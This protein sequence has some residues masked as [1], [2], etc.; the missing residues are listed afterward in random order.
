MSIVNKTRGK[1][2]AG[3]YEQASSEGA[4]AGTN[5]TAIESGAGALHKTV[6]NLAA[7]P[8]TMTDEP[9]VILH[10]GVK[11]YD[12]AAGCIL[13]LGATS[14]IVA[15]GGGNVDAAAAGDFSAGSVIASN[16]NTL[17]S[18]EATVIPSTAYTLSSSTGD[19]NGQSTG[20]TYIDGTGTDVDLYFNVLVDDS[21]HTGGTITL[22]GTITLIWLNLGTY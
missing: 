4:V 21:D 15:T 8:V 16:N 19:L 7:T 20:V 2:V 5:V 9:G 10:G 17:T 13:I 6:F 11:I 18:T 3:S 1:T 12:F 22:T 14:D